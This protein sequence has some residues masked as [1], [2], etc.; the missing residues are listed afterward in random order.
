MLLPAVQQ[1]RES[2][3]RSACINNLKQ[4]GLALHNYHD[5]HKVFPA[6]VYSSGASSSDGMVTNATG[7]VMLLPFLDQ[8][9]LFNQYNFNSAVSIYGAEGNCP[10]AV[11]YPGS[12]AT[13]SPYLPG[14][15]AGIQA[16]VALGATIIPVFYCPSDPGKKLHTSACLSDSTMS[17]RPESAR[18]SYEFSVRHPHPSVKWTTDSASTRAMFGVNS[19][20]RV[21]DITDG[22][23]NTA[24]VVESTLELEQHNWKTWSGVAWYTGGATIQDTA[25]PLNQRGCCSWG[26]PF[27]SPSTAAHKLSDGGFAGSMHE[28]GL[29]ILMGDGAVRFLNENVDYAIRRDLS[30]IAD[31]NPIGEF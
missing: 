15:T 27:T 12:V 25:R 3:R 9:N 5:T 20:S 26:T 22:T 31:G 2:A 30:R 16:N 29:H 28:G 6:M 7:W 13:G 10:D 14:T 17:P 8:A 23:S 11:L 21:R 1:A 18:S 4:I 24:A 19:N